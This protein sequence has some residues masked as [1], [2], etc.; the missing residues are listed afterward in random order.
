MSMS[1]CPECWDNICT[2]GHKYQHMDVDELKD[3]IKVLQKIVKNK[4][5]KIPWNPLLTQDIN[6]IISK[7]KK[8]TWVYFKDKNKW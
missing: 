1:D 7:N 8:I 6:E 3:L 4:T 2:C 5:K